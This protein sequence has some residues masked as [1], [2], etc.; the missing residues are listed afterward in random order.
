MRLRKQID[1]ANRSV[2]RSQDIERLIKELRPANPDPSPS[3]DIELFSHAA[4]LLGGLANLLRHVSDD[5]G[6]RF[7]GALALALHRRQQLSAR[8]FEHYADVVVRKGR[9]IKNRFGPAGGKTE[10]VDGYYLRLVP[11]PKKK[12]RS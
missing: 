9:I 6:A 10:L 5:D 1:V 11:S 2:R 8:A 3:S 12:R 4:N 7:V